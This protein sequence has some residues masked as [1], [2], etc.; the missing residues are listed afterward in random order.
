[1]EHLSNGKAAAFLCGIGGGM[2]KYIIQVDAPF[3]VKLFQ[4]GVTALICGFLGMAGK[5]AFDYLKTK[6]GGKKDA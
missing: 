1:M 3:M 2:T 5:W 4:A 6:L